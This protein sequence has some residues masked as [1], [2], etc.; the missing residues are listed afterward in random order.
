MG[1]GPF[2]IETSI[3]IEGLGKNGFPSCILIS[4]SAQIIFMCLF[5][6]EAIRIL[7]FRILFFLIF[8]LKILG[9]YIKIYE[10]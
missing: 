2:F 3:K 6:Q 9:I 4:E 8:I 5:F 1:P 10:N 7:K